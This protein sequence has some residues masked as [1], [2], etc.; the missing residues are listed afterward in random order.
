VTITYAPAPTW[1]TSVSGLG[2]Q[3][4]EFHLSMFPT[5]T[6][7]A[8]NWSANPDDCADPAW[9]CGSVF[10]GSDT[11][12]DF[13]NCRVYGSYSHTGVFDA[14]L[15]FMSSGQILKEYPVAFEAVNGQPTPSFT[16]SRPDPNVRSYVFANIDG[17]D[18]GPFPLTYELDFGDGT[19]HAT[20]QA[21]KTHVYPA[22]GT[23]HATLTV[24]D[25]E[26]LTGS[27]TVTVHVNNAAPVPR[28]TVNC[29]GLQCD[30]SAESSTDDGSNIT[31]WN[32]DF[33][34]GQTGSGARVIH[35]YA[36]GCYT[37]TLTVIDGDGASAATTLRVV[38][39]P[40]LV[41]TNTNVVVDAHVQSYSTS[42]GWQT[43]N[44]NLNG[45]L[46]PGETVV[47]EPTWPIA[48]SA[49]QLP[50]SASGVSP[51]GNEY[52]F[53]H[54]APWYDVSA[55]VSDCWSL[56]DCYAV[57]VLPQ[58]AAGRPVHADIQFNETNLATGQ[59]TPG[60]PVKIHVGNSFSDVP[61]TH[62]SYA[63]IES[64]LHGGVDA[65]CGGTQFCP[66][67]VVTRGEVARW[68][69]KAEHGGSYQPP[70][71]TSAPFTDVP[72]SHPF[73]ATSLPKLIR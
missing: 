7:P 12:C 31:T 1:R 28:V 66:G 45:I 42:S 26:G 18:D 56:G 27:R 14:T 38:A 70:P 67:A 68:L 32:W 10:I 50:V 47:V 37:V 69:L 35:P 65:G 63:D 61:T 21:D 24:S 58:F 19:P 52:G 43:T 54:T 40:P 4:D 9:G 46:E 71:C 39:G 25:G 13:Q 6:T 30:L 17:G 2:F 11:S 48:P 36:A 22:I 33:G 72:C 73:A 23:Y 34:D 20:G 51:W 62:W 29:S 5:G 15:R 49:Q 41:S 16:V 60:S 55:G 8:I 59:P 44:G 53:R 3:L 57:F 64:V